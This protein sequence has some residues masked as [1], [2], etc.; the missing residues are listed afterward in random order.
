MVV[1]LGYRNVH[2]IKPPSAGWDHRGFWDSL[3]SLRSD[4]PSYVNRG[5][6]YAIWDIK[7]NIHLLFV[8]LAMYSSHFKSTYL[9]PLAIKLNILKQMGYC[10]F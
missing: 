7:G 10:F 9:F 3:G 5:I 8:W 4:K 2:G 1:L 6:S